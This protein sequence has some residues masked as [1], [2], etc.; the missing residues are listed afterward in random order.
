MNVIG[1]SSASLFRVGDKGQTPLGER[2]PLLV[3]RGG[4]EADGVVAHE[5]GLG[6]SDHPVCSAK[7][8]C[9]EIFLMPQAGA[10]KRLSTHEDFHRFFFNLFSL[11]IYGHRLPGSTCPRGQ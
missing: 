4:R 9:A 5:P 10:N 7:V 11:R 6:V 2:S 1:F 3:R 8:A